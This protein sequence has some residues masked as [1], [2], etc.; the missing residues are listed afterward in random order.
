LELC[1]PPSQAG[2]SIATPAV[3]SAQPCPVP[4]VVMA[5][6]DYERLAGRGRSL[7]DLLMP[8]DDQ[9]FEFEPPK[10]QIVARPA[11]LD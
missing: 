9:D 3:L 1:P 4:L 10:A 8:D 7:L 2:T 5:I 6:K 11:D